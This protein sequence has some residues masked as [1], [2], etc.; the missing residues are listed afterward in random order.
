M[1]SPHQN[2]DHA[3]RLVAA[4]GAAAA[5]A[6]LGACT[7]GGTPVPA[8]TAATPTIPVLQPGRPGEPNATLTGSAAAPVTTPGI[9][10]SDTRFLRDMIVHHAQAIVMVDAVYDRLSDG[11]VRAL[12]S[13]I[14]DEQQPEIDFMAGFLEERG[15]D[16]PPEAANPRLT[17]HGGHSMP[18]MASAGDLR[19]LA[20]ATGVEADRRF[21]RL[22]VRHHEGALHM[23]GAH[24]A[25]ATDERVEELADDIN[26]TQ[27]KQIQQMAEMLA[28]LT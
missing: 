27:S 2:H 3:R 18:G 19:D 4:W 14:R 10:E 6:V 7:G 8:V 5:V 15:Q 16:A 24:R 23:V 11:Q 1:N 28:R 12:A 25:L 13:R 9:R 21:L 22:M 17:D 26:V 20:T